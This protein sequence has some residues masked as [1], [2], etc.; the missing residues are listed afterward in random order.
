MLSLIVLDD[1]HV[2]RRNLCKALVGRGYES[3]PAESGADAVR[4]LSDRSFDAALIDM[5]MPEMDGFQVVEEKAIEESGFR[6]DT[7]QGIVGRSP[8]IKKVIDLIKKVKDSNLPVLISGESG[9]GK[10]LVARALHFDSRIKSG[11]FVAVNCATLKP[12]LL[13]PSA[14]A[15]E[16]L[17]ALPCHQ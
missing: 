3:F 7:Y 14:A 15:M 11:P 1:D 6:S 4:M 8:G 10:E 12:E 17:G 2:F 5:K 9:A 13:Q 16:Q